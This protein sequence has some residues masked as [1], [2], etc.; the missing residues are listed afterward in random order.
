MNIIY[1]GKRTSQDD[2]FIS[3][4]PKRGVVASLTKAGI[5][6]KKSEQRKEK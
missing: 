4:L 3:E 5:T 1:D 2:S 6:G